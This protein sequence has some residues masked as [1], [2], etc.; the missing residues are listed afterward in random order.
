MLQVDVSSVAHLPDS[1]HCGKGIAAKPIAP[2]VNAE[3]TQK[4]LWDCRTN[5][6]ML[7]KAKEK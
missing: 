4:L 5:R 7:N 3:A 6:G 1:T 2:G